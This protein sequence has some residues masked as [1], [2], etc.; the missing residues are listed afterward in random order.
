MLTNVIGPRLFQQNEYGVFL[1]NKMKIY[2]NRKTDCKN[3]EQWVGANMSVFGYSFH[4]IL[5]TFILKGNSC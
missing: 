2:Q 3:E 5:Q 1:V 4:W